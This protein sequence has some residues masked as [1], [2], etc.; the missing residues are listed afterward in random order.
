MWELP[1]EDEIAI[2]AKRFGDAFRKETHR[3]P[4]GREVRSLIA[5]PH[6]VA[7]A[8][9][10]VQQW[11]WDDIR[12]APH[13][14]VVA[15]LTALRKSCRDDVRKLQATVDSYNENYAIPNGAEPVQLSFNF[16]EQDEDEIASP[17]H[18]TSKQEVGP[19]AGPPLQ[20]TPRSRPAP[21]KEI[22][23]KTQ[24]RQLELQDQ[25]P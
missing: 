13:E 20:R 11:L 4:Q 7:L 25:L 3:D 19:D 22:E 14:H 16:D 2:G 9:K 5:A 1:P 23:R 17:A 18:A 21:R 12:T 6:L 24:R 15:G 10:V 8:G